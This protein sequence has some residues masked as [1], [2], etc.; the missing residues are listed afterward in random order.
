MSVP[1]LI[2]TKEASRLST[3]AMGIG[4]ELNMKDVIRPKGML[5]HVIDIFTL[6][7]V[8]REKEEV[9]K[10]VIYQLKDILCYKKVTPDTLQNLEKIELHLSKMD[11]TLR[12]HNQLNGMQV[13]VSKGSEKA[14]GFIPDSNFT[15]LCSSIMIR[16]KLGLSRNS[17]L[18]TPIGEMNLEDIHETKLNEAEIYLII[19]SIPKGLQWYTTEGNKK[20]LDSICDKYLRIIEGIRDKCGKKPEVH[21]TKQPRSPAP[22]ISLYT[23]LNDQIK[24]DPG[25]ATRYTSDTS[26]DSDTQTINSFIEENRNLYNNPQNRK[27]F[28]ATRFN[29]PLTTKA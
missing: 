25:M 3:Y 29:T 23:K 22:D 20:I 8:R 6:G 11:I 16:E 18:L 9:Y 2:S 13:T 12:P 19:D 10:S 7:G 14:E 28:L 17:D 26:S 1:S 5:E 27:D 24:A 21:M 15:A 4:S